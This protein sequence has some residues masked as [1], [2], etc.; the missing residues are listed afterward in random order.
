[1]TK[2]TNVYAEVNDRQAQNV[3]SICIKLCDKFNGTPIST[4]LPVSFD[5]IRTLVGCRGVSIK[6]LINTELNVMTF[7]INNNDVKMTY[8]ISGLVK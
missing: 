5:T 6:A 4:P 8:I 3:D 7:E 2:D 1:M